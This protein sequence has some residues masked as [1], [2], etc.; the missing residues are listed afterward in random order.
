V[1]AL[2][3]FAAYMGY[4]PR[5][6]LLAWVFV[7]ITVTLMWFSFLM[8]THC[9]YLTLRGTPCNRYVRGKLRGCR[10][11]GRWKRDAMFAALGGRNPGRRFRTTWAAPAM[12]PLPTPASQRSDG[13]RSPRSDGRGAYDLAILVA[14]LLSAVA[15]VVA[16]FV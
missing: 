14:T 10:D 11:H 8:P 6:H 15:A 3:A 12:E 5:E 16:L 13:G 4:P 2:L 9:D 1:L 7:S